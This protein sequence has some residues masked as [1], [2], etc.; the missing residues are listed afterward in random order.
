MKALVIY[1]IIGCVVTGLAFGSWHRRCPNDDISALQI[2]ETAA[3]W[4]AFPM[5]A[6]TD[7]VHHAS[8]CERP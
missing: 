2:I 3:I 4:P 8:S 5:M 6:L 1:W 7:P